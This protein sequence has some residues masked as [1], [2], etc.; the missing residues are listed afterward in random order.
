[1]TN[2][3]AIKELRSIVK[4]NS[5]TLHMKEVSPREEIIFLIHNMSGELDLRFHLEFLTPLRH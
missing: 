3:G 1:M 2:L 5:Y 4:F